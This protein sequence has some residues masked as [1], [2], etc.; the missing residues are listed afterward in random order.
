MG[1]ETLMLTELCTVNVQCTEQDHHLI[2]LVLLQSPAQMRGA[3]STIDITDI[4][5][6]AIGGSR[7]KNTK[8]D[9]SAN[10]LSLGA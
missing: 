2:L 6:R 10:C 4:G 3:L 9:H 5:D 1:N 7:N 8:C